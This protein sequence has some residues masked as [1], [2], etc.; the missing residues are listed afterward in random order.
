MS[1]GVISVY[2]IAFFIAY[3]DGDNTTVAG[4]AEAEPVNMFYGQAYN[5]GDEYTGL[6]VSWATTP[7]TTVNRLQALNLT[8]TNASESSITASPDGSFLYSIWN[9]WTWDPLLPKYEEETLEDAY[10]RRVLFLVGE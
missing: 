6:P 4:G 3:D 7:I 2:N 8:G 9:Q 5:W 1:Y 10:F